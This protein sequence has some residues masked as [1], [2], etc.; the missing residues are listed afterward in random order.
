[1]S[2]NPNPNPGYQPQGGLRTLDSI[3]RAIQRYVNQGANE[4][5]IPEDIPELDYLQNLVKSGRSSLAASSDLGQGLGQFSEILGEDVGLGDFVKDRLGRE[6]PAGSRMTVA[7]AV[8]PYELQSIYQSVFGQLPTEREMPAATEEFLQNTGVGGMPSTLAAKG[9]KGGIISDIANT[10]GYLPGEIPKDLQDYLGI[11]AEGNPSGE[12]ANL[13]GGR[14][15][16]EGLTGAARLAGQLS[17]LTGVFNLP[18]QVGAA[19]EEDP[20]ARRFSPAY[21]SDL[22]AI[23]NAIARSTGYLYNRGGGYGG[24]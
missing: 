11:D 17:D 19:L 10:L 12:P 14:F 3:R 4:G 1:M 21:Q 2:W 23:R 18:G 15:T 13:A 8:S 24:Y 5:A 20:G 22:E 7:G 16:R 9:A 6:R